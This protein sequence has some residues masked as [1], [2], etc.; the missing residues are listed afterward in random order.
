[1]TVERETILKADSVISKRMECATAQ[2]LSSA[3]GMK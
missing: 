1:M 3:I 2:V